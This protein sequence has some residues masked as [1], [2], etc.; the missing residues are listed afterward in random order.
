MKFNPE[1]AGKVVR[2]PLS[3]KILDLTTV[4]LS[5]NRFSYHVPSTTTELQLEMNQKIDRIM[6]MNKE[7]AG[8]G[9][10][11]P[12]SKIWTSPQ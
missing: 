12:L 2:S 10:R 7:K 8:N 4:K 3:L 1:K 11:S 6:Q 5:K 9:V